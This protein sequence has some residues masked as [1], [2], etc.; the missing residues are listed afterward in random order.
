MAKFVGVM[1]LFD[2]QKNSV[3]MLPGYTR[4]IEKA[5]G[6]PVI[7]P[8]TQEKSVIDGIFD[9][10]G[11]FLFT[12]GQDV[13]PEIY[14]EEKLPCCGEVSPKRDFLEKY[15]FEK[16]Y[17]R[18]KAVFGIC[19][20]IQI[21]NALCGGSLWQDIPSQKENSINHAQKPPYDKPLHSVEILEHSLL[22]SILQSKN[23]DV[24]SYHH[25][26]IKT[27]GENVESMATSP[28]GICEA[29]RIKNKRFIWAVQW[30]PEFSFEKDKNQL[31]IAREFIK[32]CE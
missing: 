2:Y 3:W 18:D 13:S 31:M 23:I 20:G 22:Y 5:G 30:H 32:N 27:L 29:V 21:I 1:P 11:G 19:R 25:Q 10:C 24:N 14:C 26:G 15:V 28:D 8:L 9:I 12:G 6:I 16:A 17:E 7:F 4:L